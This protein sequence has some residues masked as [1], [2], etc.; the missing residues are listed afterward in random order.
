MARPLGLVVAGPVS[1]LFGMTPWLLVVGCIMGGS[2]LLSTLLPSVR[3]LER[4]V[5]PS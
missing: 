2:A 5:I 3:A 1:A 4:R